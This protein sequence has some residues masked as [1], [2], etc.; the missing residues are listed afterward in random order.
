MYDVHANR[1]KIRII[2]ICCFGSVLVCVLIGVL[3]ITLHQFPRRGS[4]HE[5]SSFI[6]GTT[7]VSQ[8]NALGGK[9]ADKVTYSVQKETHTTLTSGNADIVI[10]T[11]DI[12]VLLEKEAKAVAE[13][14]TGMDKSAQLARVMQNVQKDLDGNNNYI[15]TRVNVSLVN[16][17]GTWKVKQSASLARAMSGGFENVLP[18]LFKEAEVSPGQ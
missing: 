16:A 7:G 12:G 11:P 14:N 8:K 18:T 3:Y 5:I 9:Y 13:N 17:W 6:S 10:R 4:L 15:T 2:L 1:H